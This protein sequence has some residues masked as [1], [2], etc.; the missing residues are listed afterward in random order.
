MGTNF[1]LVVPTLPSFLRFFFNWVSCTRA[2]ERSSVR[3]GTFSNNIL[4][5][6]NEYRPGSGSSSWRHPSHNEVVNNL[7]ACGFLRAF[8]GQPRLLP[9][10]AK[11]FELQREQTLHLRDAPAADT[12]VAGHVSSAFFFHQLAE[13]PYWVGVSI[14]RNPHTKIKLAPTKK[15]KSANV[16]TKIFMSKKTNHKSEMDEA[17]ST[18]TIDLSFWIYPKKV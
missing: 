15:L 7:K 13:V 10:P 16:H 18:K 6:C 8:L 9:P 4:P 1:N 14:F 5:L 17:Q 3:L 11:A 2:C 12:S